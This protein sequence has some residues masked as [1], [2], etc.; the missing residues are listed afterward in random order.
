MTER[1]DLIRKSK[2]LAFL[3]RHDTDYAFDE[4]GWREVRD[5]VRNYGYSKAELEEIKF[6]IPISF[7]IPKK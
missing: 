2:H 1:K 5:L 3:L 4:H 7:K 6:N